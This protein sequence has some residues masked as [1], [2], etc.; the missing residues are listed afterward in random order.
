M[1][2]KRLVDNFYGA[3]SS[4]GLPTDTP[5]TRFLALIT[6][7]GDITA[8]LQKCGTLCPFRLHKGD[9]LQVSEVERGPASMQESTET[10]TKMGTKLIV[11]DI[12]RKWGDAVKVLTVQFF[13]PKSKEAT[14][15]AVLDAYIAATP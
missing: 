5:P 8:R 15:D 1:T 11:D 10:F 9:T 7:E 6:Y 12:A 4:S 13:I 14:A 3:S 2:A